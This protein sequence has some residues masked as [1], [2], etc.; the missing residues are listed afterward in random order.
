MLVYSQGIKENDLDAKTL[1]V[2]QEAIKLMRQGK[3]KEAS[4]KLE[5]TLSK[6]PN[7]YTA[8]LRMAGLAYDQRDYVRADAI[9]E[10]VKSKDSSYDVEMY[11][12][13]A[14]INKHLKNYQKVHSNLLI[15]LNKNTSLDP[16]KKIKIEREIEEYT[17]RDKAVKNP[18]PI[19]LKKIEGIVNTDQHSEYLPNISLEGDEMIFTRRIN[20]IEEEIYISKRK[21][22][23]WGVPSDIEN[24]NTKLNEGSASFNEDKSKIYFTRCDDKISGYG[25]CDIYFSQFENGI[26][27]QPKNMNEPINSAANETS[28]FIFNNGNSIIFSSNRKSGFGGQ[29]LYYSERKSNNK[30][31]TPMNLGPKINTP[32]NEE[33]PFIHKDNKTLFFRSNGHIGMG[34]FDLYKSTF[35]SRKKEWGEVVNMGYPINT[36][37]SEGALFVERDGVTSYYASDHEST[38]KKHLDIYTFNLPPTMQAPPVSYLKITILD[39]ESNKSINTEFIIV[40]LFSKDT[41]YVGATNQGS[42]ITALDQNKNLALIVKNDK[43]QFYTENFNTLDSYDI[44]KPLEKIIYLTAINQPKSEPIVLKNIFFKTGSSVL[45]PESDIELN[46]LANYLMKQP[47]IKIKIIGHTDN[48]GNEGDNLQLSLERAKSVYEALIRLN[49]AQQ[50]LSYDGKGE[51]QPI[52]SNDTEEGRRLNRRTEFVTV[53]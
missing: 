44:D 48:V 12:A 15:Y 1:K 6:Y 51:T 3:Y 37:G 45:L 26:W 21:D 16:V 46:S 5:K 41:V 19:L 4:K 7:F 47:Q 43:Y 8:K 52:S 38:E 22:G 18:H 24:I 31:S 34:G 53:N 49:I 13:A 32:A 17:F 28:A 30:W 42:F 11:N 25:S 33:S 10:E 9:I 20:N 40:D 36:E 27:Q 50:R 39:K 29:D 23:V 35:D 2:Y 14:E